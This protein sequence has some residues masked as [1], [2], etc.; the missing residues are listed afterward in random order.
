MCWTVGFDPTDVLAT[1]K[2]ITAR[3]SN[4]N[5]ILSLPRFSRSHDQKRRRRAPGPWRRGGSARRRSREAIAAA[6]G[7]VEH[8]SPCCAHMEVWPVRVQEGTCAGHGEGVMPATR[9]RRPHLPLSFCT[10]PR[11]TFWVDGGWLGTDAGHDVVHF[12]A[13]ASYPGD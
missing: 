1:R 2:H 3:G 5:P 12:S 4:P 8:S 6:R 10:E 13:P 9:G 7:S 11:A